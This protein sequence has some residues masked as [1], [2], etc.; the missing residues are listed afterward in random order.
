[1]ATKY[2]TVDENRETLSKTKIYNP[3]AKPVV[4]NHSYK[5]GS[6]Y[7]GE[8]LGG[9]RH[10]KGTMVWQDGA[11]YEGEW[12]LGYANGNGTFYHIDGDKY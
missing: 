6:S 5:T 2:F 11:K 10:G 8:W 12:N 1:V 9:F 7:Q 4:K 3:R